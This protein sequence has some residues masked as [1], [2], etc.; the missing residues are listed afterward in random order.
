MNQSHSSGPPFSRV[1][2]NGTPVTCRLLVGL[3]FEEETRA[4]NKRE[5]QT[6]QARPP[7][8]RRTRVSLGGEFERKE[9]G[10]KNSAT[11]CSTLQ[12]VAHLERERERAT[13]THFANTYQSGATLNACPSFWASFLLL[14][15][16]LL[17]E[18]LHSNQTR[19][20]RT[21]I[22]SAPRS[23]KAKQLCLISNVCQIS[24]KLFCSLFS[25]SC[26]HAPRPNHPTSSSGSISENCSPTV[27]ALEFWRNVLAKLMQNVQLVIGLVQSQLVRLVSD[28][29]P[30]F[31]LNFAHRLAEA[32]PEN[33]SPEEE[34]LNS[35]EEKENVRHANSTLNCTSL[36]WPFLW[37]LC[38]VGSATKSSA[39]RWHTS[40]SGTPNVQACAKLAA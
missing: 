35:P 13:G 8:A 16:G 24:H 15:G 19:F 33:K 6:K 1:H 26:L 38:R 18:L 2:V 39:S 20:L 27:E 30:E 11:H 23:I 10:A 5:L 7:L 9:V 14:V 36:L 22:L 12:P 28:L 3:K 4:G 29:L 34:S 32:R 17:I 37:G 21:W 25:R 31:R 40:G